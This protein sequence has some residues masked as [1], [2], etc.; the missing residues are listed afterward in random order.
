MSFDSILRSILDECGGGIGAALMGV[1]GIPIEQ[2]QNRGQSGLSEDIGTAGVE[3]GRILQEI[4]KASDTLGG[5]AVAETVVNMAR[6]TLL[7]RGVDEDTF[8]VLA[9]EPDGNLGKARYLMRKQLLAIR[10]EL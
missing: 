10:R 4:H 8:L 1:D 9:I 5:G 3:F 7:F 6:F 2:V